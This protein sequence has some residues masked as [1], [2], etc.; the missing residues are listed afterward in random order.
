MWKSGVFAIYFLV[1]GVCES[2]VIDPV[3]YN[4]E[5]EAHHSLRP[6]LEKTQVYWNFGGATVVSRQL[7]RLTPDTQD[8]RGW[9][10]NEYPLESEN[11][12]MEFKFEVYSKP[13]FGGDGFAMW[14]LA[15]DQDPSFSSE[16]DFLNGPIFGLKQ[17]FKGI[18]VAFDVYDND[19]KRNNPT[20][21]V[22]NNPNGDATRYSHD[23]DYSE[24]MVKDIPVNVPGHVGDSS[25]LYKN[26]KCTAD[27]RNTGKF[28]KALVKYLHKVLHVYIDTQDGQGYKFC[29]A[30]TLNSSFVDYHFAFSAA[31][32][33]V[34][35]SHDIKEIIVRYLSESDR[36]L[37]DSLLEHYGD[38]AASKG[39]F[40]FG[41]SVL[42]SLYCIGLTVYELWL[43]RSLKG[44]ARIDLVRVTQALN[45]Q[46]VGH[47]APTI[48]VVFILLCC[49]QWIPILLHIPLFGFAIFLL[50]SN[51]F[52]YSES[53]LTGQGTKGHSV[54]MSAQ[55]RLGIQLGL[56]LLPF[57]LTAFRYLRMR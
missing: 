37:D 14:L 52:R 39:S 4:H 32:G 21:F 26:Y 2:T 25:G 48:L 20:I 19:N 12:E 30:V 5:P 3:S 22:L 8:R 36:D 31:T 53:S 35:D 40:F 56:Y 43:L 1:I 38:S 46:L 41:L 9:L 27:F 18:G 49:F 28:S 16:P 50:L 6:P 54:G 17:D 55:L 24:D 23:Q 7:V 15:G 29:L 13:H 45:K 10:W 51:Q 11:W 47:W 42:L 34:A 33:Q 57:C 44:G